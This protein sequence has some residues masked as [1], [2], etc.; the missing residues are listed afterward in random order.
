MTEENNSTPEMKQDTQKVKEKSLKAKHPLSS[1]TV[2]IMLII[3][4]L[5]LSLYAGYQNLRLKE[6]LSNQDKSIEAKISRLEEKQERETLLLQKGVFKLEEKL[7]SLKKSPA[8]EKTK[9]Y[10]REDWFLLKTEYYLELAQI[11]DYFGGALNLSL[12][13]VEEAKA[14]LGEVSLLSVGPIEQDLERIIKTYKEENTLDSFQLLNRLDGLIGIIN[15]LPAKKLPSFTPSPSLSTK[16]QTWKETLIDNLSYLKNLIVIKHHEERPPIPSLDQSL[17]IEDLNMNLR[18]AKWAILQKNPERYQEALIKA[19]TSLKENISP[20]T[21]ETSILLEELES[22]QALNIN[23]PR[24]EIKRSLQALS[25][26]IKKQADL[27]PKSTEFTSLHQVLIP[28]KQNILRAENIETIVKEA[29]LTTKNQ[30]L[31]KGETKK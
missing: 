23:P 10:K 27:A 9:P 24:P 16:N 21:K 11:N 26:V 31:K 8:E 25:E 29:L 6:A 5:G 13:L 28:L 20:Q 7:S 12:N 14:S 22:L 4:C 2:L 18:E 19:F 1:K 15:Q 17:V 30:N 3:L